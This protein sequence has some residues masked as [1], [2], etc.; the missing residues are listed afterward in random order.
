MLLLTF[1]FINH[2]VKSRFNKEYQVSVQTIPIPTDDASINLGKHIATIKGCGDC[3]GQNFSGQVVI[4]DPAIGFLAGPNITRGKGGLLSRHKTYT[5]EDYVR[6][7]K[8]GIGQ[9]NKT[10]KLMPSYEYNPLSKKDLGALIAYLKSLPPVDNE[11]PPIRL[12]P[13]AYVLTH[14]DK[15]PLVAAERVDH[16]TQSQEEVLPEVSAAY[17]QY[18]A[19]SCTGCH[20]DNFQGGSAIVPGSPDV[21]N[22]NSSGNLGKWSEAQFIQTLRTGITPEGKKMNAKFMPWKMTKE[23]TDTEIKSLYKFLKS[24]PG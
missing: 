1:L 9:D 16:S 2:K 14:F 17:G 11:T 20:R 23:Y 5:D 7:I 19:V 8:H 18:V 24:L 3:H 12:N 10:L 22:I 13:L 6:A 4:D 15:L 21:P